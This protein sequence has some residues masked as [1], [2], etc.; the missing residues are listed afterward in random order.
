M[1]V[2]GTQEHVGYEGFIGKEGPWVPGLWEILVGMYP[3][4]GSH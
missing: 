3:R 1:G 4:V 2:H